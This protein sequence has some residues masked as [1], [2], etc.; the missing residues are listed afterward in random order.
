[1]L[2]SEKGESLESWEG[3][4]IS[5]FF[6]KTKEKFVLEKYSMLYGECFMY[7]S[8]QRGSCSRVW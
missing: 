4:E 3:T 5:F 8:N 6:F 1:M 7:V 2:V